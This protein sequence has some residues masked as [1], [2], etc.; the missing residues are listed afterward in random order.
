MI[1]APVFESK[2]PVGSSASRIEGLLTSA[3]AIATR[4]RCPPDSSFG[5]GSCC[6]KLDFLSALGARGLRSPAEHAGVHKRQLDVVQRVARG[7]R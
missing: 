2:L 4:W 1:S 7:R 5:D 3:R 6:R